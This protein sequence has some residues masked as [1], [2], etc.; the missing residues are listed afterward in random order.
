MTSQA[1]HYVSFIASVNEKSAQSL[2]G[3]CGDFIKTGVNDVWLLLSTPGGSVAHGLTLYNN[4][5]AM[6][7]KLT[8]FNTGSVD[9]IGNVIFM[10]GKRRYATRNSLF[11]FHGVT[12]SAP[13]GVVFDEMLTKERLEAIQADHA[14]IADVIS[15][16]S[17]LSVQKIEEYFLQSKT[18]APEEA[19]TDGLIHEIRDLEIPDGAP[20]IQLVL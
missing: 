3:V 15:Q 2:L 1:T 14:R 16:N 9:S 19:L 17:K 5:K 8:T 4:L 12:F 11:L 10:A 7:F 6:P 13:P 20:F 18:K